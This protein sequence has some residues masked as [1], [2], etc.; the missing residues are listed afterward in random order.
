VELEQKTRGDASAGQTYWFWKFIFVFI[1]IH[2][3]AWKNENKKPGSQ[4]KGNSL[5][6]P[7]LRGKLYN[8]A[9]VGPARTTLSSPGCSYDLCSVL[10]FIPL[11]I[12]FPTALARS[13]VAY[14]KTTQA[15][16]GS[17]WPVFRRQV[18]CCWSLQTAGG[19]NQVRRN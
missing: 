5:S 10:E 11:V 12:Y 13:C 3:G 9:F 7:W 14:F 8:F 17:L 19:N 18:L 2:S 1:E 16:I 4:T 6:V 15:Q